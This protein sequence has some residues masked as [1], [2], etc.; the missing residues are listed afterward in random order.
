M[1]TGDPDDVLTLILLLGHPEVDLRAVTITPGTPHQV[2]VA[3]NVLQRMGRPDLPVGAFNLDHMKARGTSDERYVTCVSGW[4]W[5]FLGELEPSRAAE[6]GW[7]VLLA[8]LDKRTT[9]VTGAPLKN[10]GALLR[11]LTKNPPDPGFRFNWVAQGGFAG[12]GIVPEKDQLPKFKGMTT[13]PT[14]NLNGDPKSALLAL[15]SPWIHSRKFVSKNVCHGVVYDQALHEM[16]AERIQEL[17]EGVHRHSLETIYQG[18]SKYLKKRPSGKAFHDPLAACCAINHSI[19][20]WVD[21]QL[22]REK[23]QWGSRVAHPINA[24]IITSYDRKRFINTL[25]GR[26]AD[27]G[28]HEVNPLGG[29]GR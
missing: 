21:V 22:Y 12:E 26:P 9:L 13:C 24:S 17:P 27:D 5:R 10:L 20:K 6:P 11:H 18:M 19:G 15:G 4:H 8:N 3:R 1:E 16:F 28:G 7:E 14:Y 29:D 23:G 25:L 2:A